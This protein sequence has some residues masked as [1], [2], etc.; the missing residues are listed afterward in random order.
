V[1]TPQQLGLSSKFTTSEGLTTISFKPEYLP[2]GK[3]YTARLSL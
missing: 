1:Q 3:L 2:S